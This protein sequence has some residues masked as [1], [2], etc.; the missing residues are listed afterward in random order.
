MRPM[1]SKKRAEWLFSGLF[2]LGAGRRWRA[3]SVCFPTYQ[4][5]KCNIEWQ[6]TTSKIEEYTRLAFLFEYDYGW[7]LWVGERERKTIWGG[8]QEVNYAP[9]LTDKHHASE[10]GDVPFRRP[11]NNDFVAS[12]SSIE[13][14]PMSPR[15]WLSSIRWRESTPKRPCNP[16]KGRVVRLSTLRSDGQTPLLCRKRKKNFW[17]HKYMLRVK[18]KVKG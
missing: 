17:E 11:P 18:V 7:A 14:T 13:G 5:V 2:P 6:R 16:R 9:F 8:E 15:A 4:K 12:T 3:A 10:T 1:H